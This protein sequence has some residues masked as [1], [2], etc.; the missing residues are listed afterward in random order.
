MK[1]SL[2][3]FLISKRPF[4]GEVFLLSSSNRS[5]LE[6]INCVNESC[7]LFFFLRREMLGSKLNSSSKRCYESKATGGFV[8]NIK[9]KKTRD[10]ETKN[11]YLVS[12]ASCKKT[13]TMERKQGSWFKSNTCIGIPSRGNKRRRLPSSPRHYQE[14]AYHCSRG[15]SEVLF[16]RHETCPSFSSRVNDLGI[17]RR[18]DKTAGEIIYTEVCIRL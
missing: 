13:S 14:K 9:D 5:C 18:D 10:G 12:I 1:V 3:C 8:Q 2:G 11:R 15:T 4:G 7:F 17:S 6:M 16:R